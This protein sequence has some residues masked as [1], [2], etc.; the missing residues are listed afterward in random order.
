MKNPPFTYHRP[1]NL[2][3]ALDLLAEHGDE[4]KVL[5]GGQSLLP[6]LALRLGAP[7]HLL[8]IGRLPDLDRIDVAD[9][10]TVT[11]GALV[12]HAAAERSVELVTA[13]P[14]IHQAMPHVGH[15]AIRTRGTV[16]GSIA[17]ADAAA[18][19]PAVCVATGATMVARSASGVREIRAGEF[20]DGYLST[21]L[22]ADELLTEVRFPPWPA[23]TT[24]TVVE[25]SRRHGDYAMVGL[26]CAVR[27]EDD[28]IAGAAL[29][30]FG[31]ATTPVRATAAEQLMV[32][33]VPSPALFDRAAAAVT[34]QLMPTG[35]GQASANY[36]RH[37]AGVLTRRALTALTSP[38]T[39]AA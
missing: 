13:A 21:A 28:R 38:E 2:P 23:G 9:D 37:V 33:E 12:T 4:I 1:E 35:D 19:M 15:R 8:D 26:A 31:V 39:A 29:A 6:I 3:A 11:I 20:F 5:A 7:E 14:L 30:F 24:G 32:G 27:R 36:R 34:E 18:E 22:R 25:V 10:G 16:V 17:H